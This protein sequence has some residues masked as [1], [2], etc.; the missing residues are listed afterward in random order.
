MYLTPG[1]PVTLPGRWG[2]AGGRLWSPYPQS[3]PSTAPAVTKQTA[4]CIDNLGLPGSYQKKHGLPTCDTP[5]TSL[6][7]AQIPS[8]RLLPRVERLWA[9][10]WGPTSETPFPLKGYQL[11]R[12]A[13]TEVNAGA[14]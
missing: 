7:R 8:H 3:P 14:R 6:I 13:P 10:M 9:C 1:S 12:G 5:L 2:G 4:S 11:L